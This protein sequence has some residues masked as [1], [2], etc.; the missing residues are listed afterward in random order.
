MP[1]KTAKAT[2]KITKS[3]KRA[4]VK[5]LAA[6][7]VLDKH[8]SALFQAVDAVLKELGIQARVEQ[9]HLATAGE[10]QT[11]TPAPSSPLMAAAV[12][13]FPPC[14]PGQIKRRVCFRDASGTIRCEDRCVPV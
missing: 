7:D 4:T 9:L 6:S 12:P 2:R 8:G 11:E 3:K 1:K 10:R 5:M 14:P 13:M